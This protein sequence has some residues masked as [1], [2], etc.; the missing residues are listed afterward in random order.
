MRALGRALRVREPLRREVDGH[1]RVDLAEHRREEQRLHRERRALEP[2]RRGERAEIDPHALVAPTLDGVHAA[3]E[4]L[5]GSELAREPRGRRPARER[6]EHVRRDRV[7]RLVR[8]RDRDAELREPRARV[9]RGREVAR[10]AHREAIDGLE[11]DL[12]RIEER[13]LHLEPPVLAA[14]DDA[15]SDAEAGERARLR[16]HVRIIHDGGAR[17][18]ENARLPTPARGATLSM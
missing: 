1:V 9:A 10:L 18:K 12:A 5:G 8:E 4:D 3:V 6:D 15:V 2:R 7:H 13:V 11:H 16:G 17:E 14:D